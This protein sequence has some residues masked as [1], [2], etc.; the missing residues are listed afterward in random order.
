MQNTNRNLI[1]VVL[2]SF[3]YRP[4]LAAAEIQ[5]TNSLLSISNLSLHIGHILFFGVFTLMIIMIYRN[6]RKRIYLN[7][8]MVHFIGTVKD[9]QKSL[10]L[11]KGPLEEII[12]DENITD[13]QKIKLNVA[14]WGTNS[15][16]GIVVHLIEQEKSNKYFQYLLKSAASKNANLKENI[17]EEIVTYK[18]QKDTLELTKPEHQ[19][20]K[21]T[22]NDQLFL[23]KVIT[24]LKTNIEDPNFTVDTLCQKI[25]MSRSSFYHKMKNLTNLAPADFVRLYRL[26]QAKELLETHRYSISEVAYKTGF[27][28][29]KYFRSVFKKQYDS[30]PGSF[31]KG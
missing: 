29:V 17:D 3:F 26:D 4:S 19:S 6:W 8:K 22:P 9:F 10:E 11:I 1:L 28:D 15:I 12:K 25:G 27:S 23:E 13:M 30:T 18:K 2:A 20:E 16:Q 7:K 24:I 21:E 31:T 5:Q 14:I